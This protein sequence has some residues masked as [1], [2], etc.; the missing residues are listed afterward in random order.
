M[1]DLLAVGGAG[2]KRDKLELKEDPSKGVYV[3]VLCMHGTLDHFGGIAERSSSAI[4]RKLRRAVFALF[5][6]SS[7]PAEIVSG[8][9]AFIIIF[10]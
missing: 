2:E 5:L 6:L 1:R 3:K 8:M 10:S 9:I 4:N 7:R